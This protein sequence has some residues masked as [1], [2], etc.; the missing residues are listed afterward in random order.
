MQ[1]GNKS[2]EES[3][4]ASG[5][6]GTGVCA[7]ELG[8]PCGSRTGARSGS[9]CCGLTRPGLHSQVGAAAAEELT[10]WTQGNSRPASSRS[11][12][13]RDGDCKGWS[14]GRA[15]VSPC[16]AAGLRPGFGSAPASLRPSYCLWLEA[17]VSAADGA[18][19]GAWAALRGLRCVVSFPHS[20]QCP[21]LMRK[22]GLLRQLQRQG[23]GLTCLFS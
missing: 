21:E 15:S 8:G 18:N 11:R 12:R 19:R 10:L 23:S 16:G 4:S 20:V 3:F 13:P 17:S 5:A 9:T 6:F 1:L 22:S 2:A 7:R 14:A